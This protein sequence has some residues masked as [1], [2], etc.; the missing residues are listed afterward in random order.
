[1]ISTSMLKIKNKKTAILPH[2]WQVKMVI[3]KILKLVI[4]VVN[5]ILEVS[6]TKKE[7]YRIS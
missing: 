5:M 1:M 7:I 4:E 6:S 2:N 3:I